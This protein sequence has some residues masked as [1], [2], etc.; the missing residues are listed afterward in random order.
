M[1][2]NFY[3]YLSTLKDVNSKL[4]YFLEYIGFSLK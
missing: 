3:Y 4:N 1:G 2:S